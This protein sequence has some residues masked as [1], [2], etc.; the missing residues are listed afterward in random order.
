MLALN[1]R[2][3]YTPNITD[4]FDLQAGYTHNNSGWGDA[5]SPAEYADVQ[6]KNQ[7]QSLKWNRDLI[8]GDGKSICIT[9]ELR[10]RTTSTRG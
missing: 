4:T 7:Y 3:M 2:A 9:T 5:D 6:F 1:L 8:N 10:V